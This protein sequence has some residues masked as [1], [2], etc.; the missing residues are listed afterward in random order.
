MAEA[1]TG[2]AHKAYIDVDGSIASPTWV[3]L[4]AVIGTSGTGGTW[5]TFEA[6][7]RDVD[8]TLVKPVSLDVKPTITMARRPGTT[9][10]D[11]LLTAFRTK[12]KVGLALM[13][14]L[15]AQAGS[16][17]LQGE[18]YV[19]GCDADEAPES[20][21]VTFTVGLAIDYVTAPAYVVIA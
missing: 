4:T 14:D 5:S 3:L 7:P 15:I 19:T 20:G 9:G 2:K 8:F 10:Y 16:K 18:F 21:E 12:A 17:G 13:T 6:S 11:T 1:I